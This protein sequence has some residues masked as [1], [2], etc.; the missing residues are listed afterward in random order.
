MFKALA[1][2]FVVFLG[3]FTIGS[4]MGCLTAL[5]RRPPSTRRVALSPS[6]SFQMTKFT[7]IRDFPLLETTLFV[8]MSYSTF[9]ASEAAGLT[10]NSLLRRPTASTLLLATRHRT[11]RGCVFRLLG[12]VAVLFCGIFQAHYTFNNL[13]QESK[14]RTRDV[15]RSQSR[16]RVVL[17]LFV[18]VV[19]IVQFSCRELHLHLHRHHVV[20]VSQPEMEH[21]VHR[22]VNSERHAVGH[23]SSPQVARLV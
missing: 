7:Y 8:L 1:N 21:S 20:H 6:F 12:I 16:R 15:S 18:L 23:G 22:L 17:H 19:R 9:L 11:E 14:Q 3:S 10:G 13:S 5:V 4:G 2:F